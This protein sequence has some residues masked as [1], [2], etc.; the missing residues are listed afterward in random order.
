[1]KDLRAPLRL[2]VAGVILVG[3][4]AVAW[5]A[6]TWSSRRPE[7]L[8]VA[9]IL[10]ALTVAAK[11]SP[12]H[13]SMKM[14]F[15]AT[16]AA[17]FAAALALPPFLAIAVA[18]G[19]T[20]VGQRFA[21][22]ATRFYNRAFNASVSALSTGAAAAVAWSLIPAA[23]SLIGSIEVIAAAAVTKYLVHT[24]LVDTAA[25]LQLRHRPFAGWWSIH[26]RDL[27]PHAALYVLGAAAAFAATTAPWAL[28]LFAIPSLAVLQNS[29][30][31]ARLRLQTRLAVREIA[32]LIDLRDPYT[33]GHS[34]RVSALAERLARR[35]KLQASQVELIA[36]AARLHDIG[37][38]A[39]PDRVLLKPDSLEDAER[40]EME[41]HT[42]IGYRI[43]SRMFDFQEGAELVRAHHERFDGS[44]YPHRQAG[45]D[46]PLEVWVIQVA[47]AYDAM[48]S[49][50][51]YRRGM[52]WSAVREQL[53]A[54]RGTQWHPGVIDAFVAMIEADVA[55]APAAP[56]PMATAPGTL[57][58]AG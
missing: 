15:T 24:S 11:L 17:T 46:L 43:V 34:Q 20:L 25:A 23:S 58:A 57:S 39:T 35:M 19:G 40:S 13:L 45:P 9:G 31:N 50:R 7:D 3:V 32:D 14:K 29:R 44:G 49:D 26:R 33:H 42:E 55:R 30:E 54:G 36:E 48:T 41:R 28:F 2:Y 37:K 21:S 53:I 52:P 51:P 6:A 56:A 18:G 27:L 47:D 12:V 4:A 16:D 22:S 8:F 10:F 38:L 5:S 1:M